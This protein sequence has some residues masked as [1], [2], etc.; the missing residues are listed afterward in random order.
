VIFFRG[1]IPLSPR[2]RRAGSGFILREIQPCKLPVILLRCRIICLCGLFLVIE[3]AQTNPFILVVDVGNPSFFTL[4]PCIK[5][6]YHEEKK[7]HE[8]FLDATADRPAFV[9]N[10]Y[11]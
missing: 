11:G 8:E 3:S 2:L 6:G 9:K 7:A 10:Y 4:S 5:M 1:G